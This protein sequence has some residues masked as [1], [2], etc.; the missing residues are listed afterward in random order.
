MMITNT[1]FL[2]TLAI[3]VPPIA[4]ALGVVLGAWLTRLGF[5]MERDEDSDLK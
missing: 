1:I 4:L 5:Q 2:G 3:I